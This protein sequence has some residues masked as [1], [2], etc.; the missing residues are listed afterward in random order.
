MSLIT[1]GTL[2]TVAVAMAVLA[3]MALVG[4][5]FFLRDVAR[6]RRFRRERAVFYAR[7]KSRWRAGDE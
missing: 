2:A 5:F 1:S 3:S 7:L 6:R 4:C